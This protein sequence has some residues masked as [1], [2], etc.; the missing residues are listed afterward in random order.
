MPGYSYD[1][2][3]ARSLTAV[4][5]Q[6]MREETGKKEWALKEKSGPKVLRWFG[7]K[8]PSDEAVAQEERRV[9]YFKHMAA[10]WD[11][12][13][14]AERF[15]YQGVQPIPKQIGN[16]MGGFDYVRNR[17]PGGA[18]YFLPRSVGGSGGLGIGWDGDPKRGNAVEILRMAPD[19]HTMSF[20]HTRYETAEDDGSSWG[21]FSE[22]IKTPVKTY[23]GVSDE[24]LAAVFARQTGIRL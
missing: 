5:V 14:L 4:L 11:S 20:F 19:K 18:Y 12:Y 16:A 2:R 24:D 21:P 8:K 1:R 10:A 15:A 17:L 9:Q 22:L 23:K 6:K 13:A 7:A 3:I